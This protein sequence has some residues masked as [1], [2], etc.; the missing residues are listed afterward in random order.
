MTE[1][2]R[3]PNLEDFA[4]IAMLLGHDYAARAQGRL[5]DYLCRFEGNWNSAWHSL[6]A[7]PPYCRSSGAIG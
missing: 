7:K 4:G 3:M 2:D 1:A 6:C 5:D